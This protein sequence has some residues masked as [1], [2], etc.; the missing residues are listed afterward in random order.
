M[1][2]LPSLRLPVVLLGASLILV[3][4]CLDE[5]A[6]GPALPPEDDRAEPTSTEASTQ[7]WIVDC[8]VDVAAGEITCADADLDSD[9]I[10][11]EVIGGQDQYVTLANDPVELNGSILTADVWVENLLPQ[12]LGTPDGTTATGIRV[13]FHSAPTNG[14]TINNA[15]G[16]GTFTASGQDYFEYSRIAQP[17][18]RT[19]RKPWEF[20]LPDGVDAFTFQVYVDAELPRPDGWVEITPGTD[21]LAQSESVQLSAQAYDL[22][23]REVTRSF[24]WSTSDASIVSVD[25][26]GSITGEATGGPVTI[27]AVSDGPEPDGQAV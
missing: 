8:Q 14:V 7:G 23:G 13:F 18:D 15:D 12:P 21:G 10:Q 6:S 27:S 24:T 5:D 3:P 16:T 17:L 19:V 4:G 1:P 22:V 2:K 11:G 20:A 26:S 9:T 25:G